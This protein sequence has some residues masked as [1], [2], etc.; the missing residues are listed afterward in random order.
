MPLFFAPIKIEG[1][2]N[3]GIINAGDVVLNANKINRAQSD[4]DNCRNIGDGK[5]IFDQNTTIDARIVPVDWTVL[6][7]DFI[8]K[9]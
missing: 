1:V 3:G 5:V 7:K 4:G 2:E 9:N 8:D 6:D